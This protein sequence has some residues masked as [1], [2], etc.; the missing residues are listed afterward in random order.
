MEW[1]DH[2]LMIRDAKE[3]CEER[4]LRRVPPRNPQSLR[5]RMTMILHHGRRS[6]GSARWK[7]SVES[8]E[9]RVVLS[10][11]ITEFPVV[12]MPPGVIYGVEAIASGPD[13][14]VWFTDRERDEIG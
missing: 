6:R 7:C 5:R 13:G 4:S 1:M 8:L 14:K 9:D 3:A 12:T 2:S 10:G 11:E